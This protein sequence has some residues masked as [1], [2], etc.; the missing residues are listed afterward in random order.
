MKF[1]SNEAK[2]IYLKAR[3]EANL[4]SRGVKLMTYFIK[5]AK[6]MDRAMEDL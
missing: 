5:Y 2:K 3:R 4:N 1:E 6:D